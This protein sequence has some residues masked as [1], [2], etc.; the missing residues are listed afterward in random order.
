MFKNYL[1]TAYRNLYKTKVFSFINILGLALG[2]A[3]CLLI[4][5][6]VNFE[7]S[8]DRF[9]PDHER[10]YRL[11]YERTDEQGQS[12]RFA[13][14]CPPAAPRI[15]ENYPE[16]EKIGRLFRYRASV[17]HGDIRFFEEKMYF[18]EPEIFEILKFQFIESDPVKS[19]Q[20]PG[21]AFLSVTSA[22]KYF[23]AEN[24]I[25][26]I[27]SVDKKEDYQ[28]VGL[29]EDIPKNSHLKFD[30]LLPF[31]KLESLFGPDYTEAWGHTGSFTYLRVKPG[32][33][34]RTFETKLLDLVEAECP[35]LK[36]YNMTMHLPMQPLTDIHLTSHFMQEYEAN[37]DR[38]SVHFL[39]I[40]AICIIVMA[41]VNYMNLSTARALSRA[42]EVRL[43]KVVGANRRQ[44]M[45][46]FFMETAFLNT[47]ALFI[48][49]GLVALSMPFF[50]DLTRVPGSFHIWS[51]A[52][53]YPIV[54]VMFAA[55][56]LFS[57]FYPVLAMSSFEPMHVLK[58]K[59][60]NA[61]GKMNL[62]KGLVIFQF[63]VALILMTGTATVYRQVSF[64]RNKDLGFSK[65]QV[66]VVKAPRVRDDAYA[67]KVT[68]F[69]E[70]L[71]ANLSIEKISH[72]TEVPG[73]QLYWDAGGIHR[74]G[75]NISESK[76]YQIMGVDYDFADVFDLEFIRGRNFSKEFSTDSEALILNETAIRWMGFENADSAMGQQVDY[77]GNIF[78]IIGILK[79]YHQQSP[80][81][82]FE[83]TI[84]RFMPTGRDVRGLF[85]IRLNTQNIREI[86]QLIRKQYDVFFPDNPFDYFFLDEYYN[87][88]YHSDELFGK[89][90]SL[91]SLLALCITALGIFGLSS[92]SA[93]QRTREIGIRKAVGASVTRIVVLLT[94]GYLLLLCT[95]FLISLP[96][97]FFGLQNWLNQFAF[98]M[99]L[100]A[101]LFIVPLIIT[102]IITLMTVSYQTIKAATANP[103]DSLKYE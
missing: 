88:Q 34:S 75:T 87:Q 20:D 85:A 21:N 19:L 89:V 41:W 100:S 59:L 31:T 51:Q 56:I 46:Q 82:A 84:F 92:Y 2:M 16:V 76:N 47:V 91:F 27:M 42:K 13:S 5:H 18:A 4:L 57:G 29:F 25:G 99:S 102:L 55:G 61:P 65:D 72:V 39:M 48:A 6:Y 101:W 49:L 64:M 26:K 53:F 73:R 1:K 67:E 15:R 7:K 30:I 90:F 28:I 9:H 60:E 50:S 43:R 69:K 86:V 63:V 23:G 40:V 33:D 95:S 79:D 96:I 103:V 22:K 38:E 70:T 74:A 78:T 80:K 14:C 37:G 45:I 68:S 94:K 32:T 11:R 93:I 98:R 54:L 12:V 66:L 24:P 8:Y 71:L 36:E 17:S 44:L 58:G 81:E 62:R 35:W 77:W 97:L 83:P 3:I 52:W 10:I